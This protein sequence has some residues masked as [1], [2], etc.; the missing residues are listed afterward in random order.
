MKT[1][2]L[3]YPLILIVL[4]GSSCQREEW[5]CKRAK[6]PVVSDNYEMDPVSSI[7]IKLE[8]N[9][10]INF[11]EDA[12]ETTLEIEAKESI[13]NKINV[14]ELSNDLVI[15]FDGCYKGNGSITI[16][17]T[18]P[19]L[20]ALTLNGSGDIK[21]K[22][23]CITEALAL[24]LRGSGNLEIDVNAEGLDSEID[25]SGNIEISGLTDNHSIG[26][27]GSGDINAFRLNTDV[28]KVDIQGSGDA[29]ISA[30]DYLEVDISG[31]GNVRYKGNPFL[32][33]NISGSGDVKNVN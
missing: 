9:T 8:A 24:H 20:E 22:G 30:N 1:R 5:N 25:G 31:S 16:E 26:V 18:T 14:S 17:I 19:T 33:V 28:T 12:I 32:D 27:D 29:D 2:K 6:G 13:I 11:D 7:N 15:D 3:F 4:I 10:I 23:T 21:C